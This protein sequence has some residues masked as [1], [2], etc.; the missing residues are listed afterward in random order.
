MNNFAYVLGV[1]LG[2]YLCMFLFEYN[3]MMYFGKDIPW[4]ADILCGAATSIINVP[5]AVVA[6][7]LNCGD[8]TTPFFKV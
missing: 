3:L 2:L 8:I 4:Y 7:I 5:C 6:F 1:V